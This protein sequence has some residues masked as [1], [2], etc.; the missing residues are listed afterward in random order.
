MDFSSKDHAVI[1]DYICWWLGGLTA[2]YIS[3]ETLLYIIQIEDDNNPSATGCDLIYLS[4]TA[5]LKYLIRVQAKDQAASGGGGG[6]VLK[7][8]S[9]SVGGVTVSQEWATDTGQAAVASGWDKVLE[10]LLN[11]PNSIGC[12]ITSSEAAS[13]STGNMVI[14]GVS[15]SERER[16]NS[17]LDSFS[18]KSYERSYS[19]TG[20]P[21]PSSRWFK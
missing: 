17:D 18:G 14:G 8:R 3:D 2:A 11:N 12:A 7:K 10:D 1:A 9:E 19:A 21:Y 4:T 20:N 5:T 13:S 16:V 15:V 6:S